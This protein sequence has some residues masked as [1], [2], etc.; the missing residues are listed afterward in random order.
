MS[1]EAPNNKCT[2]TANWVLIQ[3]ARRARHLEVASYERRTMFEDNWPGFPQVRQC[4]NQP[5]VL[6]AICL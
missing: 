6:N 3:Y 2:F 1:T 4:S 5:T